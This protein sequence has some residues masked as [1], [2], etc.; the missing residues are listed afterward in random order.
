MKQILFLAVLTLFSCS[1]A[2]LVQKAKKAND[3]LAQRYPDAVI[4]LDTVTKTIEVTKTD[5]LI[6]I[7][8]LDN[9]VTITKR[10]RDTVFIEK[11]IYSQPDY[12]GIK[13]NSQTRQEERTKRTQSRNET[14]QTKSTNK[15]ETKQNNSNNKKDVKIKRI[16]TKTG[17][18]W[19][20]TILLIVLFGVFG[21]ILND[22][23][24]G[25]N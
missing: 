14:K 13:T 12:S 24:K 17:C 22:K 7:D 6:Q 19:W 1:E 11:L 2:R 23:L 20:V 5:T 21:W 4:P 18:P 9:V 15:A 10:I 8:T 3:R 16:E 25:N